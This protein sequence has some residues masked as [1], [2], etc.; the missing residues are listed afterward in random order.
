MSDHIVEIT[1]AELPQNLKTLWLKAL[2]AVELQNHGYAV[3]L[4]NAVLKDA[5]G[6]L[7]GR[8]LSRQCSVR[9]TAGKKKKV[10]AL[11][12]LLSGGVN[13]MKL[14]AAAKKDPASALIQIE[15]E[16]EKEPYD[17]AINEVL[18]DTALSMGL[19]ETA[20]F[21]LE[22]VR[23][24]APE[25]TKLLHKLA[26]HYLSSERPDLATE[27]YND[28]VKQEPGDIR[29]VKGAKDSSA[30][31]SMKKQKWGEDAS[32]DELKKDSEEAKKL[33]EAD[34]SAL[35]RD[36]QKAKL[37]ELIQQYQQD[38]N[39]LNVVKQ[40][41]SL[42]E[43]MEEWTDA[44]A[45]F[46]WAYQISNG[47]AALKQKAAELGDRVARESLK[48]LEAQLAADPNNDA[49]RAQVDEARRAHAAEAVAV[50]SKR[51]EENPTDPQLRFELGEALYNAGDYSEAIPH[52]QQATRNPH[53]RT[54]VLLTLARA[55]DGKGMHDLAIKQLADALAD[56]QVMDTTKKEVLYE[57][58][59]IHS[60]M[61][62]A[63][64]ALECFKQIYEVDYG[65]RD[66]ANRVESS[67][68]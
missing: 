5:P 20:A 9:L 35:T 56:L 50:A 6:F 64:D 7:E 65:Y 43:D 66:V 54:K 39:D 57:K 24:G 11:G 34:R 17:P 38:Q 44:H 15:K 53:I 37:A 59:L 61:D 30:K 51:V 33:E 25:N 28:I 26:E 40:I 19:P 62:A 68:S 46:D 27:V 21:A 60:K 47:D 23:E 13:T 3:N 41:A 32:L 14:S 63:A 29:A 18:F 45:F 42:Y 10:S 58:G 8:K 67:Y 36:Q 55:F 16:L 22:T 12:G 2:S 49:L 48:D 4:I 1:E 31:A 52:L